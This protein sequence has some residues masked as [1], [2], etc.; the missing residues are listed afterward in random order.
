MNSDSPIAMLDVAAQ[1][2]PLAEE[3]RAV[4]ARVLESGRFILGPEVTAFEAEVAEL[5]GVSHA[6]GV[7]S[8][9]DALLVALMA[10][11]VGAG[12]EVITT[13]FTFF[14]TAGSIARLGAKPVFVDIDPV[15]FNLDVAAVEAAITP[16]TRA[17]LPVHLFGQ[18]CDMRA[19]GDIAKRHSLA[20]VED[21]AQ[22]LGA[23]TEDGS[24]GSLG[25]FG[26]FSFFPSKNLGGFGDGGLVTTNDAE[27][28]ERARVL[29]GHGAKPKYFHALVGGNFRID[30]LMAA[31]LR[32][33][34]PHLADYTAGRRANAARYDA[35]FAEADL[36]E[37][38]VAPKCV[39]EGHVYNQYV[40]RTS[41]RDELAAHLAER[42]ISTA[43]YYPKS[44]HEQACFADLGYATGAFPESERATREVLAL[45]IYGE[46]PEA[47]I[48]RV[49]AEVV[50]FCA[51]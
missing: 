25:D 37:R 24:T 11:G 43:I 36:G 21:A 26:C 20:L 17:I 8:G 33:K 22:A 40:I 12:D 51:G 15:S 2:A 46:L 19:L 13:P 16:R 31:L 34:L 6:L 44:L 48:E 45:P 30:A 35:L 3:L 41:E 14:A 42:G 49:A 32:V 23:T 9:T 7:S 18:P 10:L 50:A 47:S 38:L 29:R 28:Y 1:N 39:E 5:V 4:F 27:L